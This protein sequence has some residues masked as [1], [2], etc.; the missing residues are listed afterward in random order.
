MKATIKKVKDGRWFVSIEGYDV[1]AVFDA[2]EHDQAVKSAYDEGCDDFW[3]Q[4]SSRVGRAFD[5]SGIEYF[6]L[7]KMVQ[8]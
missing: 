1:T 6:V 7:R 2:D 3:I 8:A 4:Y 5:R